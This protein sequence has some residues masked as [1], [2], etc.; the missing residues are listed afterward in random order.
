VQPVRNKLISLSHELDPFMT[1][2]QQQLV[3][4]SAG[5]YQMSAELVSILGVL[6]LV[7]TAVGLYGVISYGVAQRTREIG[8]RTALGAN[9]S[10]ILKFV[11]REVAAVGAL[12]IVLGLPLALLCAQSASAMLFG[13]APWD[14]TAFSAAGI[15]LVIV[16]F[17]AGVIPARRAAR[18]DPMVALRY[19]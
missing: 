17:A 4:Y 9:R 15:L 16:L 10:T 12:G 7:L 3:A 6:G 19:E 5:P 14:I 13:I 1:T 18:V 11:L 2:T 8:I